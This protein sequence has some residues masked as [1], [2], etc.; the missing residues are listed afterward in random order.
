MTTYKRVLDPTSSSPM[1]LEYVRVAGVATMRS[2]YVSSSAY[3]RCSPMASTTAVNNLIDTLV[4]SVSSYTPVAGDTVGV[5]IDMIALVVRVTVW[6]FTVAIDLTRAGTA[7][8]AGMRTAATNVL[9][10]GLTDGLKVALGFPATMKLGL[11]GDSIVSNLYNTAH[12][13]LTAGGQ[14]ATK[15]AV[16]GATVQTQFAT[17]QASAVRGDLSYTAFYLQCGVNNVL[18]DN[19][20]ASTGAAMAT[21]LADINTTNPNAIVLLEIMDPAAARMISTAPDRLPIFNALQAIYLGFGAQ[22]SISDALNDGSGNLAPAYNNGD[23][24]HP[25]PAGDTLSAT[26]LRAWMVATFQIS[27]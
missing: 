18:A 2:S 16:A 6:N 7:F 23:N 1:T 24:L 4:N 10:Q 3:N 22:T 15:I 25:N 12:S 14:T 21:F 20:A 5:L 9:N 11:L 27:P 13:T 8:T 17:W 19:S 26:I